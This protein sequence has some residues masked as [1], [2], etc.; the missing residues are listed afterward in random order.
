MTRPRSTPAYVERIAFMCDSFAAIFSS[1]VKPLASI[2]NMARED[3]ENA[4]KFGTS[5]YG[6]VF[7]NGLRLCRQDGAPHKE[8]L[9]NGPI[10]CKVDGMAE[11][12]RPWALR[13]AAPGELVASFPTSTLNFAI[14]DG[15]SSQVFHPRGHQ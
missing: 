12:G 9:P 14:S 13:D 8:A 15:A 10:P 3:L 7:R 2:Y 4:L 11:G 1:S 6:E 5:L